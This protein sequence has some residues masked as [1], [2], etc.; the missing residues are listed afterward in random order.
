VNCLLSAS[1]RLFQN[2]T[3]PKFP[4]RVFL[5][6]AKPAILKGFGAPNKTA[7]SL[8]P[9]RNSL[10]DSTL[11]QIALLFRLDRCISADSGADGR[12]DWLLFES[13]GLLARAD[14]SEVR[15]ITV[16]ERGMP[17]REITEG[18]S[19]SGVKKGIIIKTSGI[20]TRNEFLLDLLSRRAR[21]AITDL[22]CSIWRTRKA[23]FVPPW[24][25]FTIRGIYVIL[26]RNLRACGG[27]P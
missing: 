7:V 24:I 9:M 27:G 15:G 17:E 20:G 3:T 25:I 22:S 19:P 13:C 4:P 26:P 6:A 11:M 12:I 21:S 2:R 16:C 10:R 18:W 5:F 8:F 1:S 14:R 23:G